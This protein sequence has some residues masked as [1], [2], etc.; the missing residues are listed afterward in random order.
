MV[1]T[2]WANKIVKSIE[3]ITPRIAVILN[4]ETGGYEFGKLD[5]K[6]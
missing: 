2:Y 1:Y 3:T 5:I 4:Q 6:N